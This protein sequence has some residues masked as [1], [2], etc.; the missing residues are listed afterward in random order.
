MKEEV[1]ILLGSPVARAMRVYGGYAPSAT[2]RVRLADGRRAFFKG[3]SAANNEFMRRGLEIEER[4]YRDLGGDIV[5]WAPRYHGA[6]RADG[7]HALLLE[8]LGPA[9]VPPWTVS[10]VRRA[11][12]DYAAFHSATSGNRLPKWLPRRQYWTSFTDRWRLLGAAPD[13][14]DQ[15]S[16]LAGTRRSEARA[17]LGEHIPVLQGA[18]ERAAAIVGPSSLLH[19]DSRSDN[20]RTRGGL[21]LF[22]WNWVCVGPREFDVVELAQS[23]AAEAGPQPETFVRAYRERAEL[24]D[25]ALDGLVAAIAGIFARGA[26]RPPPA[27]LPRVRTI[28]RRQLRAALSWAARRLGLPEPGWLDAVPD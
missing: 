7:W 17:W 18:A 27:D 3:V 6:V 4:L 19:L 22:D 9:D 11:A 13:D 24:R 28:Q 2:F 10:N 25:E 14:I 8:D 1:A 21:R 26:W 20:L 15:L 23:I 5:R 16:G 12:H